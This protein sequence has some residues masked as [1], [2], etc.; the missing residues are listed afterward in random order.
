MKLFFAVLLSTPLFIESQEV[1]AGDILFLKVQELEGEISALRSELESQAYLIDKLLNEN[2][3]KV[4]INNTVDTQAQVAENSFR[5][6]GINDGQS[7][8]EVYEQAIS[9]LNNKN[10]E[11][12]KKSFVYLADNFSDDEKIPLSLFW[13]GEISLLESNLEQSETFFQLLAVNH[14]DHWRTPLAHK[15]I[16]DIFMMS[17]ELG[18]AKIKYQFVVQTYPNNAAS[19]LALQLLENME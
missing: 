5:F 15:K 14:P 9:Q 7:I 16:G 13:L 6:E 1:D 3:S 8:D 18:A 10:F 11:D 19:S 4:E 17:G 12:A 2:Q